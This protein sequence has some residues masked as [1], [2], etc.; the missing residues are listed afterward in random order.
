MKVPLTPFTTTFFLFPFLLGGTYFVMLS[1]YVISIY[2][3]Q[4]FI[5]IGGKRM[6][7]HNKGAGLFSQGSGGLLGGN[8]GPRMINL[9]AASQG[10]TGNGMAT[11]GL[12]NTFSV[13]AHLPP[14]HTLSPYSPAVYAAYLVDSKG[15]SGFY[16]G[17]LRAAGNG[18]YQCNFKSPVPLIHYNK[19]SI[20][21]ESPHNIGQAPQGPI[22]MKVKEGL[23]DGF[24]PVKKVGGDMWG[25]VKGFV[26]NRFGRSA[27]VPEESIDPG[28]S[29]QQIPVQP[30]QPPPQYGGGQGVYQQ[31]NKGYQGYQANQPNQAYQQNQAYQG[32]Q[33]GGYRH[34]GY[35]QGRGLYPPET[36][37]APM[38]PAPPFTPIQQA[39]QY[40]P[41]NANPHA[42]MMGQQQ[43]QINPLQQ[44]PLPNSDENLE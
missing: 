44:A 43:A 10:F 14:P 8:S 13:I 9:V 5:N 42:S 6:F 4:V 26:G 17:T 24:G 3:Q 33:G 19:V 34:N 38:P 27:E 36:Y 22:I 7:G 37:R 30:M 11:I 41:P 35:P 40:Q 21:L 32:G 2:L 29:Q 15:K 18:M 20:S 16:A 28:P 31:S 23:M 25:K 12:D 39:P 1:Y